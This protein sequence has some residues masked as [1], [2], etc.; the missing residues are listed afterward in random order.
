MLKVLEVQREDFEKALDCARGKWQTGLLLGTE[1]INPWSY[2]NGTAANCIGNWGRRYK[3]RYTNFVLRLDE[4]GIVHYYVYLDQ[5]KLVWC[6]GEDGPLNK[7]NASILAGKGLL[8]QKDINRFIK[9]YK[10]PYVDAL[11]HQIAVLKL[12]GKVVREFTE[13]VI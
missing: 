11:K 6:F 2:G 13:V 12:E 7:E 4:A 3:L 5:G 10:Y 9:K 1:H 8:K